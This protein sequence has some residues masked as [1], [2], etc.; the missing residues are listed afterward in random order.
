M[1][2]NICL[3]RCVC[4]LG[5]DSNLIH[6]VRFGDSLSMGKVVIHAS[7]VVGRAMVDCLRA[8]YPRVWRHLILSCD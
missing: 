1:D 6:D 4:V 2:V 3:Y 5:D 8:W 7:C